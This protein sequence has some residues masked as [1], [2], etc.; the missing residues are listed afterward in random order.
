VAGQIDFSKIRPH[1]TSQRLAFEEL[2]FQLFEHELSSYERYERPGAP[3]A[4]I[5][6]IAWRSDG[7]AHGW[8][9]KF[10]TD[11]LGSDELQQMKDSFESA[12]KTYP[13]ITEYTF[14]VP[15]NPPAGALR[16]RRKS[17]MAKLRE[18]IERWEK[19]AKD[20]GSNVS[21]RYVGES[22]LM[23]E[24]TKDKTRVVTQDG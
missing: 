8:Q 9:A 22:E 20:Q 18:A 23:A 4:G 1:E 3:D 11:R 21:I 5:E 10:F 19:W 16:M 24:L 2:C 15:L 14:L 7:S 17:A 6:W 13:E 12:I